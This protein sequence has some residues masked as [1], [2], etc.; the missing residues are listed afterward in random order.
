MVH[1]TLVMTSFLAPAAVEPVAPGGVPT[2][3]VIIACYNAAG[4]VGE[5][6]RGATIQVPTPDGTVRLKIPKGSQS[7][8]RPGF[9][10]SASFVGQG[11]YVDCPIEVNGVPTPSI[12]S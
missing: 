9:D 10:Y 4:T 12:S 1:R 3:S 6:I 2:F 8:Q 7:G 11:R 5:A